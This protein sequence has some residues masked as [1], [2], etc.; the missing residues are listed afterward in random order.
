MF[1]RSFL[2]VAWWSV[3]WL[4]LVGVSTTSRSHAED[5]QY[6]IVVY[7]GTSGG[8][9]AAI[10]ASK[11]GYSVVL[12]EPS[13]HL[14]GLTTGGLGATDIGNKRA[15][16]GMAREFYQR[17]HRVYRNPDRWS[18]ETREDYFRGKTFNKEN[19]DSMWTFEPHIASEVFRAWLSESQVVLLMNERLDRAQ[20]VIKS[21]TRIER[22]CMESGKT[23]AAKMFI[24]ATYEGDLMATAG[25]SYHVGREANATYGETINGLQRAKTIHHQFTKQVDPFLERGNP[26]SGLLPFVTAKPDGVDGDGDHRIQAYN[27]RMCTTD[28]PEN[29]LPWPKPENYDERDFEL[30]FRN[31]EAGDMRVPWAPIYMPNRKTDVNNNFA[32]STDFIGMNYRYPNGSYAE[33]AAIWREHER[34]QKGLMWS[35]ANHPRVPESIRQIFQKNGLAADEFRETGGWPPQMYVREARRMIGEYVMSEKNC[36]RREVVEDSIGMGAYN[37]DSHNT[38]RHVTD[39]GFVRNEG[40]VQIPTKPYPISYR[41]ICPPRNQCT[42]LL[43]PVCLSASHIAYG[44]IRMEPVFMVLGQSSAIAASIGIRSERSVQDIPYDSL[45]PLLMEAGQVL[46]FQSP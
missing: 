43:V 32:F 13:G 39:D 10:A 45:K 30:L 9:V 38:Q 23:F 6:D 2:S 14:G 22:V 36:L 33:R 8:I 15:I 46:D 20:G 11:R 19:E 25:V 17:I 28:E 29:R 41:S 35:L 4:I 16:G 3:A 31:F 44:S 12:I 21:G 27:F 7:G 40:D 1:A 42:N 37:M 26:K 24:D 18:H 5:T 34:Y